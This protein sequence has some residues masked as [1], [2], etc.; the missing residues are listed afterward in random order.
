MF[1]LEYKLCYILL[2]YKIVISVKKSDHMRLTHLIAHKVVRNFPK[3]LCNPCDWINILMNWKKRNVG[4]PMK[5]AWT[6]SL[7]ASHGAFDG[8]TLWH[9]LS[10]SLGWCGTCER[11]D[12][13]GTLVYKV[14]GRVCGYLGSALKV[15]GRVGVSVWE[16]V[17]IWPKVDEKTQRCC[18]NTNIRAIYIL[19]IVQLRGCSPIV[20]VLMGGFA[21]NGL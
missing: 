3:I 17:P 12:D 9:G 18:P 19:W 5:Q 13:H 1:V 21:T 10:N 20:L 2:K 16:W 11:S 7:F 4:F 15:C 14:C 6:K 8:G